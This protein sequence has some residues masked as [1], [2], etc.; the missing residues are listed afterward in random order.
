MAETTQKLATTLR[1]IAELATTQVGG[2]LL[3]AFREP[4]RKDFKRDRHDIVTHFDRGA[5]ERI[6]SLI[7]H[8]WPD[9]QF[10]G[11]EFGLRGKGSVVWHIDPIDGTSNFSRGLPTWCT[12]IAAVVEGEVIAG[13]IRHHVSGD[14]FSADLTG[15][16]LNN[17]KMI[18][19]AN[20]EQL[21]ATIVGSFPNAKDITLFGD[22]AFSGERIL[23]DTF[24]A[25]RNLGSGAMNLAYVA[26]GW[27]DATF[28]FNTNSWDI[29]AGSLILKQA[30]GR[31]SGF[32]QGRPTTVDHLAT[33]YYGIGNSTQYPVLAQFVESFSELSGV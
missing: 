6:T 22:R 10:V 32:N 25:V 27:A 14:L 3:S 12:S 31:F 29:A 4:M 23:L 17:N 2:Y 28:G 16:R 30:G 24:Q 11:E 13:A 33:D 9:S 19:T 15:A 5:E 8:K 20:I 21:D 26:A 18:S 1:E 7:M